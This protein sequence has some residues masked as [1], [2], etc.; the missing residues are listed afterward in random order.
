MCVRNCAWPFVF[1]GEAGLLYV[2]WSSEILSM[3]L[4][5]SRPAEVGLEDE[6]KVRLQKCV[7]LAKYFKLS[8]ERP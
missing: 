2:A 3:R 8:Y 6:L 1:P 7:M 5:L 4:G